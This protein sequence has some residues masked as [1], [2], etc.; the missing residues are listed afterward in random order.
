MPSLNEGLSSGGRV[1][2]NI[3]GG[4]AQVKVKAKWRRSKGEADDPEK[5]CYSPATYSWESGAHVGIRAAGF[6]IGRG[7]CMLDW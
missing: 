3:N 4:G 6:S 1:C 7:K 2:L 5:W